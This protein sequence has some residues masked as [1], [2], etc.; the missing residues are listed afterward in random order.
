MIG[1]VLLFVVLPAALFIALLVVYIRLKPPTIAEF[2]TF[3]VSL[4]RVG[5]EDSYIIYRNGEKRLEFYSGSAVGKQALLRASREISEEDIHTALP[6]LALGLAK[7]G[8]RQYSICKEGK[9]EMIASG[10][11]KTER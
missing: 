11:C 3:S 2:P 4:S 8:F 1:S 10:Q 5:R 6:N 7:L 9:P